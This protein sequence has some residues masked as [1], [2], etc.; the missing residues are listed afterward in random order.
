M[1]K[2]GLRGGAVGL[3]LLGA[4]ACLQAKVEPKPE[5]QVV[6]LLELQV[7]APGM[8][9]ELVEQ[10]IV[11]P[12]E[13]ALVGNSDIRQIIAEAR[14]GRARIQLSLSNR[15]ELVAVD[16]LQRV[17]DIQSKLP[18]D[19]NPPV[20]RPRDLQPT[21]LHFALADGDSEAAQT[22]VRALEATAGVREVSQCG[23][24]RT[25]VI[26]VDPERMRNMGVALTQ[27]EHAIRS[28]LL[29]Q[30]AITPEALHE[31]ALP[32]PDGV[33]ITIGDLAE[34]RIELEPRGCTTFTE[35]G[36]SWGFSVTVAHSEAAASVAAQLNEARER[37]LVVQRFDS[38]LHL[39]LT[40][41][42]EPEPI[43]ERVRELA[44]AG[45][46]LEVG[47]DADPCAGPGTLARLHLPSGAT[48]A[49]MIDTLAATPGVALV[50]HPDNLRARRWLQGPDI[51]VLA[52]LG[53]E[54]AASAGSAAL[55]DGEPTSERVVELDHE[56][57]A[58]L[59]LDRNSVTLT[60]AAALDGLEL[61][62]IRDAGAVILRLGSSSETELAQLPL[63]SADGQSVALATV[64]AL[65]DEVARARICR[66]NGE[67]GVVLLLRP[68][69][70]GT[71]IELE[72]PAGYSWGDAR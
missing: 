3:A 1:A 65:R 43:V 68:Q 28:A 47:V 41:G 62:H 13:L 52:R 48:L 39:W 40:P 59:G 38:R 60:L 8:S 12:I 55:L 27:L 69:D 9:A 61:G 18:E 67:R 7:D 15:A 16:V 25:L 11:Q 49:S 63:A 33:A 46:M 64:A 23:L 5:P 56:K 37:G 42:I 36:Q 50:E 32:R 54:A 6:A 10:S 53:G 19:V 2:P 31:L 66:R 17:T 57:L 21:T 26:D 45:W 20:L 14:E 30:P 44:G 34:L 58:A 51:E 70:A 72:L 29:M 22:L 24:A 4:A 35:Q 71:Q